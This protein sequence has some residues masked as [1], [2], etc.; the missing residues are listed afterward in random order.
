MSLHQVSCAATPHHEKV[1]LKFIK[2]G[3]MWLLHAIALDYEIITGHVQKDMAKQRAQ[4][5]HYKKERA[6]RVR[7]IREER[8]G[9][10]N[11][12]AWKKSTSIKMTKQSR[13]IGILWNAI[14]GDMWTE[15]HIS[16]FTKC[17]KEMS[18]KMVVKC[19]SER[20][21]DY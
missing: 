7:L 3:L 18:V 13:F 11:V 9:I 17:I 8:L 2:K 6:E 10:D 14:E 1:A 21:M 16:L 4:E 5:E 20:Q 12:M 15:I 19:F